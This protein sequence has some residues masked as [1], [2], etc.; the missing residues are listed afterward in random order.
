MTRALT[1]FGAAA[2]WMTLV[3]PLSTAALV[4]AATGATGPVRTWIVALFLAL[5]PGLALLRLL[6]FSFEPLVDV[7]YTVTTSIAVAGVAAG[8]SVYANAWNPNSTV[9]VLAALS[10]A[11]ASLAAGRRARGAAAVRHQKRIKAHALPDRA[12]IRTVA[13]SVSPELDGLQRG[14]EDLDE[15]YAA[16]E[17]SRAQILASLERSERG[18]GFGKLRTAVRAAGGQVRRTRATVKRIFRSSE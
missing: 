1:R 18:I 11:I 13:A 7:G 14:L 3:I 6:G 12:G 8:V 2:H 4:V 9:A 16:L 17:S 5:C 10:L 15:L